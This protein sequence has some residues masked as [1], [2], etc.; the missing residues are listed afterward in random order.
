MIRMNMAAYENF[1]FVNKRSPWN[2]YFIGV[3]SR[4]TPQNSLYFHFYQLVCFIFFIEQ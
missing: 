3:L 2:T 1:N 4:E